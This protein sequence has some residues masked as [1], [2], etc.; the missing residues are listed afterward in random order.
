M[1]RSWSGKSGRRLKGALLHCLFLV[2]SGNAYAEYFVPTTLGGSL[3]YGYGYSRVETGESEQ[4]SLVLTVNGGGYFWQ[5]W[6]LVMSAGVSVGL[7]EAESTTSV[8]T[9]SKTAGGNV[10]LTLFP[11]SRFPTSVGF[12][13]SDS[14]QEVQENI[15]FNGQDYRVRRIYIR[16]LYTTLDGTVFNLNLSQNMVSL[17][18]QTSDAVDRSLGL[19]VRRRL[20]HHD[21]EFSGN[22]FENEPA[23]TTLKNT[24]LNLLF[25]HNYLPST[26]V[27]VNSLA[28]H[29]STEST[30]GGFAG[31]EFNYDQLSSTFYWRPEHRP[32]FISG[33]ARVFQMS[34]GG[35]SRGVATNAN[36]SYRLTRNINLGAS[37]TVNASDS[38]GRQ[39]T[40]S[41]QSLSASYFSDNY[42]IIGFD[43]GWNAN[44]SF[45]NTISRSDATT[46]TVGDET[47]ADSQNVTGSVSHRLS[48]SWLLGRSSSVNFGFGQ[49]AGASKASDNADVPWTLSNSASAGW[50]HH[51]FGG[52][53]SIN[54]SVSDSRVFSESDTSY[55]VASAQVARNQE[56]SRLSTLS[57]SA[58][59]QASR[60][61]SPAISEDGDT[62]TRESK[63]AGAA[64]SYGHGRFLGVH[65]LVFSSQL[66][67]PNLLASDETTVQSTTEWDNTLNYRIGLLSLSL[68]ARMRESGVGQR[69]YSLSFQAIRTF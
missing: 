15:N 41:A 58:T 28:S 6:F 63:S 54:M 53:T 3:G 21:L 44:A 32:Y 45:A 35:E 48:R 19:E 27:G 1:M 67:F 61:T 64:F 68:I 18:G 59:F 33:G 14:R 9:T 5:P 49:G 55:Q 50:N 7:G 20:S 17:S 34:S 66:V 57:G 39:S 11:E 29:S 43:Y 4:T 13:Q 38:A 25:A 60:T 62:E 2:A 8:G 47:T 37:V 26:E 42:V 12:S 23:S 24:S 65:N 46:N 31:T 22:Y 40:D 30:G 69:A 56:L 16:Q 52:S 36:A 51:G 10:D